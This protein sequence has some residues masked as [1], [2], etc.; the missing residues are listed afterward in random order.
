MTSNAFLSDTDIPNVPNSSGI[1]SYSHTWPHVLGGS[2]IGRVAAQFQ[3][4]QL[5]DIEDDPAYG[6]VQFRAAAWAMGDVSMTY[7]SAG[8]WS[9]QAYCRNFTNNLV[10]TSGAYSTTTQAFTESFYPPRIFGAI[11]SARF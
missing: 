8:A 11:I 3:S 2:L 10:P 6:V 5:L 7:Q 4:S 9:V 1:V